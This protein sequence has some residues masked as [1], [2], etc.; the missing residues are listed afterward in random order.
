MGEREKE[1]RGR[2]EACVGSRRRVVIACGGS[3][4]M[5]IVRGTGSSCTPDR[6]RN[7]D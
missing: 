2:R 5:E 7:K 3:E 6:A 1:R 4:Q